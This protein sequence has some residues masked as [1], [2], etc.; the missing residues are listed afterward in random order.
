[1]NID[2]V[3]LFDSLDDVSPSLMLVLAV[4]GKAPA[5]LEVPKAYPVHPSGVV[6]R[7]S[8][9]FPSLAIIELEADI[10]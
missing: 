8:A 3:P 2:L 4:L 6:E 5:L 9:S 10:T 7:A 1:M